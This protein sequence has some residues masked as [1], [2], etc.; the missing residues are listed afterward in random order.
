[1]LTHIISKELRDIIGTAKFAVTFGVGAVLIV[2]AFLAGA[3]NYQAS[4]ARYEAAKGENMR[5][6]DGVTDWI[7]VRDNRIFLPPQPLASLVAG[8]SNDI[9][10]TVQ[11]EGRGEVSATDSR[12]SE[13]TA[14]AGFRLLDLDFVFQI[15]LSL[16]GI[17]FAY[18]AVN[19]EKER[20]TLGL[21]FANALPRTVYITGKVLGTFLA[22]AVPLLIPVLIG[23]AILP[24]MRVPLSSDE[25][26][27]LA[28]IILAGLLYTGVFVTLSVAVSSLTSRSSSSF[29]FLLVIWIFAVL[30][31][32][33][34]SVLLAGRAVDVLSVDEV[35]ARKAQL[36]R[37]LFAE[38]REKT[39]QFKPSATGDPGAM[40]K[41]FQQF[42]DK[43]ADERDKKMR[44]LS[45]RLNEERHNAQ[46]VQERLA[47]GL[48][49]FSP[50]AALSLAAGGLA[51]TSLSLKDHF[52]ASAGAYQA[53]FG[54][55][56]LEKT[57]MNPGGG[58]IVMRMRNDTGEK[59]KP[60]NPYELP[61]FRYRPIRLADVFQ[62]VLLNLAILLAFNAV[63]VAVAFRAFLR[64]DLR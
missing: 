5:K 48:A 54:R 9:G 4:M 3:R 38:D 14:L 52:L 15:V 60:I 32:P 56:M 26:I 11:I 18:D 53:E 19:G 61:E 21:A 24:L 41:E 55:F 37:Q 13:E 36:G 27:R 25:W 16:L 43:L 50:S 12:Y 22:L 23:C 45:T 20:G 10:R 63:F 39:A 2:F 30:I 58:T 8:V 44:E 57:G 47:L 62:G 34:A 49:R 6:L 35:A 51:G 33:R 28:L 46:Q 40:M 7:S 59:P 42:M 17:L 1:M 29:L 64:Y 31:I